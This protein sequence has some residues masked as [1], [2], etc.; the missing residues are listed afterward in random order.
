MKIKS[1]VRFVKHPLLLAHPDFITCV[2]ENII[3]NK[4]ADKDLPAL[5]ELIEK[6]SIVNIFDTVAS[7]IERM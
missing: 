3:S 7:D 1:D 6:L 4:K 5:K 2:N